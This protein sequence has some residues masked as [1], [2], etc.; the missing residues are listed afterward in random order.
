VAEHLDPSGVQGEQGAHQPD[1]GRLAAP[2]RAQDAVDLSTAD[3]DRD[4]VHGHDALAL[5][6]APHHEHLGDV[7]DQQGRNAF[8]REDAVRARGRRRCRSHRLRLRLFQHGGHLGFLWVIGHHSLGL[9]LTP[10]K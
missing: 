9:M 5:A 8:V 2:V 3:P 10:M 7:L 1:Q 4:V 6:P